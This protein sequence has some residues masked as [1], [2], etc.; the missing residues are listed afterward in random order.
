MATTS[1]TQRSLALL[2]EAGMLA[3]VVERWNPHA[4]LRQDLFGCIDI[5][6]LDNGR[7]VAVQTTTRSN[8]SSRVTKIVE[9]DAYPFMIRAGWN[10]EVHGWFRDSA[11]RWQVKVLAL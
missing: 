3:A 4:R 10:I 5:I 1:P 6:A 2:R 7:T 11:K 8:M 9:S